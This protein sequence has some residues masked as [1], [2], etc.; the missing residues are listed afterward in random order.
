ME[1][2]RKLGRKER[3]DREE[4]LMKELDELRKKVGE[5]E[6][7]KKELE[8]EIGRLKEELKEKKDSE[9]QDCPFPFTDVDSLLKLK[10]KFSLEEIVR[11]RKDDL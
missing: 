9:T 7:E 4:Q 3:A 11:L 1:E 2:A 8:E 6:E 10:E 5:V